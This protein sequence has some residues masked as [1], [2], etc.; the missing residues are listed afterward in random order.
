MCDNYTIA[1]S[2]I[3]LIII[4]CSVLELGQLM[5]RAKTGMDGRSARTADYADV[6]RSCMACEVLFL[7]KE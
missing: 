1:E 4:C 6:Q 2:H 3:M 5:F 7:V